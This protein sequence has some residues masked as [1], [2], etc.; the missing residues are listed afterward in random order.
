MT[1]FRGR[2]FNVCRTSDTRWFEL[3][4]TLARHVIDIDTY[5][6]TRD[7]AAYNGGLFWHTDHY[8]DAATST[9]RCYSRANRGS[10]GRN[11]GGGPCNEHNYTTGLLHYYYLTGNP[12]ARD[13]VL[14]LADW[15]IAMDDGRR[16]VFGL[17]DAGATGSASSTTEPDYHGPGRGC[18]NSVNA[19]LDAWLLTCDRGY[20]DKAEQ[21][22]R[23]VVHP[24]ANIAEL[25]LLNVERRWSYTVFLTVLARYLSLKLEHG[26]QDQMYDYAQSSLTHFAGWM[27]GNEVPYFDHPEKLEYP[28]EA[29]AAHELRKA[30]VL[31]LAAAHVDEPLRSRWFRRGNE[32]AERAWSDL[33]RFESRHS[34][35]AVAIM[36]Q[37][38]LRDTQF[39]GCTIASQLR[40]SGVAD[41]G[42]PESFVPQK[43]RVLAQF[44]TPHGLAGVLGK[45]LSPRNWG[46]FLADYRGDRK[47]FGGSSKGAPRGF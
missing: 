20:L 32:L 9:H 7:R 37:E 22:I 4:D 14:G 17:I 8:R 39:R 38:G 11:Y 15:V 27:A 46:R 5:H 41:H 40:S 23:R 2:F 30:N 36:L 29:W 25:D 6:T 28:T 16:T 26:E 10:A 31:R 43:R 18:G 42:T 19:L 24:A 35:R 3:C 12:Q 33:L 47:T 34:A 44:K 21:L 13:T 1:W 45:V